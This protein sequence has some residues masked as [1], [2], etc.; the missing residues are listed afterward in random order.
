MAAL[1][2]KTKNPLPLANS[3]V[4]SLVQNDKMVMVAGASEE[5]AG[6]LVRRFCKLY[7]R[8]DYKLSI[9]LHPVEERL[10]ALTFPGDIDFA[11]YF[12]LVK[13]LNNPDDEYPAMKAIGWCTVPPIELSQP[14]SKWVMVFS[15]DG[16]AVHLTTQENIC[17]KIDFDRNRYEA[18]SLLQP[19]SKP[20]RT[21]QSL[22]E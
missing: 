20:P 4:A 7:D 21:Y 10:M 16:K 5:E 15:M 17:W 9:K 1:F 22:P 18:S 14:V 2:K 11:V 19:F 3:K 12:Y 6:A 8:N 13:Y